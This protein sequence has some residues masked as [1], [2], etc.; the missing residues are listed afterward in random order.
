MCVKGAWRGAKKE[1][2]PF[3]LDAILKKGSYP[4]FARD[5]VARVPEWAVILAFR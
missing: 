4:F 2:D 5:V 1:Y 3:L